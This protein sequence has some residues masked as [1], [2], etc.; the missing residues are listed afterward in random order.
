M[1]GFL[2][3]FSSRKVHFDLEVVE[4]IEYEDYCLVGDHAAGELVKVLGVLVYFLRA[5][6][7]HVGTIAKHVGTIA[8]YVK[9]PLPP[10]LIGVSF[11]FVFWTSGPARV[12]A[13]LGRGARWARSLPPGSPWYKYE[14]SR[15][16]LWVDWVVRQCMVEDW[17]ERAEAAEADAKAARDEAKAAAEKAA[18][19]AIAAR[20]AAFAGWGEAIAGW[21]EANARL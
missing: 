9:P 10:W 12:G 17:R 3:K 1:S 14:L 11:F 20:Y 19:E 2:W 16:L 18:A 6:A 4:V 7:H 5:L 15:P 8:G 21:E 13:L